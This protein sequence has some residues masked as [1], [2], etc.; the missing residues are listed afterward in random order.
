MRAGKMDRKVTLQ[1]FT[2][3][4]NDYGEPVE[5]WTKL[6][7]VWAERVPLSG[8]EAFIADQIAALSLVKYRIRH[9]TDVTPKARIL[10]AGSY[11]DIRAV[12]IIGRNEGLELIAESVT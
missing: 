2:S 1:T 8:R 9:R 11:Y 4:Q 6:A 10:D 5:T 7:E 12:N 3:T